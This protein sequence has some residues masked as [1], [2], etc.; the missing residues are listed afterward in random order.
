MSEA[1]EKHNILLE[2]HEKLKSES[3]KMEKRIEE[4][5]S[6][7][8]RELERVKSERDAIVNEKTKIE[9]DLKVSFNER[10]AK[11][12]K[13]SEELKKLRE[14]L[15]E[16]K[17]LSKESREARERNEEALKDSKKEIERISRLYEE[18]KANA[19]EAEKQKES[20]DRQLEELKVEYEDKMKKLEE[21]S[22]TESAVGVVKSDKNGKEEE[23]KIEMEDSI[24]SGET[25]SDDDMRGVYG[26]DDDDDDHHDDENVDDTHEGES[27]SS[28]FEDVKSENKEDKEKMDIAEND[29]GKPH[30][31]ND[32]A[33]YDRGEKQDEREE[34][35]IDSSAKETEHAASAKSRDDIAEEIGEDDDDVDM[36]EATFNDKDDFKAREIGEEK[37]IEEDGYTNEENVARRVSSSFP[38][39]VLAAKDKIVV[40]LKPLEPY[41][42]KFLNILSVALSEATSKAWESNEGVKLTKI[43]EK[44]ESKLQEFLERYVDK[45]FKTS[46]A[47]D[48]V[49]IR[50]SVRVIVFAP[51][52]LTTIFFMS[53]VSSFLGLNDSSSK[54]STGV[55]ANH[56][57]TKVSGDASGR[58]DQMNMGTAPPPQQSIGGGGDGGRTGSGSMQQK[59]YQQSQSASA[60]L[61]NP[62]LPPNA[63]VSGSR[64]DDL[65]AQSVPFIP[66]S[67]TITSNVGGANMNGAGN[68]N[69]DRKNSGDSASSGANGMS[70][71]G[72]KHDLSNNSL[73][74]R[75]GSG[76]HPPPTM[77]GDLATA[78]VSSGG[79]EDVYKAPPKFGVPHGD[80]NNPAISPTAGSVPTNANLFVPSPATSPRATA[81]GSGNGGNSGD[82][83]GGSGDVMTAMATMPPSVVPISQNPPIPQLDRALTL[84]SPMQE[85]RL[86]TVDGDVDAEIKG[87]ENVPRRQMKKMSTRGRKNTKST[88]RNP[89]S[90]VTS[91][92][93]C[94]SS[95]ISALMTR[96]DVSC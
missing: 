23:K 1:H 91:Q 68:H 77:M 46:F 18:A 94:K 56:N 62:M 54:K 50:Q 24:P 81:M 39:S 38:D 89:R 14:E 70:G 74:G 12:M 13:Q 41:L 15:M 34:S 69:L 37:E 49:V 20:F 72:M 76:E 88:P 21:L 44:C 67:T 3:E 43:L 32:D 51:P 80:I 35:E 19:S 90:S 83:G 78:G 93:R 63:G 8:E 55:A 25:S 96:P 73:I 30:N 59:Q 33:G 5:L 52:F 11:E 65:S 2:Q 36:D 82:G 84:T 10:N 28:S 9:A 26:D 86:N 60:M 48:E 57:K 66:G 40:A 58:N 75:P 4:A 45:V 53:F 16:I 64:T 6:A 87:G 61:M 92:P 79:D 27:P 85:Q 17:S 29:Q 71:A 47:R 22:L 42:D 7:H 95:L 31:E